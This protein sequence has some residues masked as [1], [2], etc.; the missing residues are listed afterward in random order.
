M[1]FVGFDPTA[2]A[3]LAEPPD[4]DT[5]QWLAATREIDIAGEAVKRRRSNLTSRP[6]SMGSNR[7]DATSVHK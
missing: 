7:P 1:S 3:L 4:R 5:D 2:V 6:T